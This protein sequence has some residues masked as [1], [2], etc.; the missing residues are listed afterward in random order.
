MTKQEGFSEGTPLWELS[1]KH[2]TT[3]EEELS[4]KAVK[5]QLLTIMEY[6]YQSDQS[7]VGRGAMFSTEKQTH[8]TA[9]WSRT[10]KFRSNWSDQ[11]EFDWPGC[12]RLQ[13]LRPRP[14]STRDERQ[15]VRMISN[16]SAS[17][18]RVR[19]GVSKCQ[20]K[21]FVLSRTQ[22]NIFT[23]NSVPHHILIQ[24]TRSTNWNSSSRIKSSLE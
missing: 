17:V 2:R 12:R 23:L 7:K 22:R 15:I 9:Q 24:R 3:I 5:L 14:L 11:T 19:K 13:S 20:Q 21:L 8:I 1:R 10:V 16:K 6:S 4:R 18:E